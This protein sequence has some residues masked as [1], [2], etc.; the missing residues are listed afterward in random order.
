MIVLVKRLVTF[1][2]GG[3]I[4]V[5]GACAPLPTQIP[6][7]GVTGIPTETPGIP[8]TGTDLDNT[9]WMF[10][11]FSEGGAG[12][13]V[14][15]GTNV[16]LSFQENGQ[17]GGSGGCNAFSTQYQAGNGTIS[18]GPIAST[19]MACTSEGVT[20]QEQK[21]FDALQSADRYELA[22]DTLRILYVNGQNSLAFSRTTTITPVQPT[23]SLTM[24]APTMVHSTAT[25]VEVNDAERI[26]FKPG[27]TS[28]SLTGKLAASASK[29]YVLRALAGQTMS[30]NLT[31]TEG[32]AILLVWGEDGDVLLSDHAEASRL[33]RVLPTTQDYFI[34]VKGGP[35]GNTSYNMT[36]DIP[37]LNTG[38]ERIEFPSGGTSAT[39]AGQLSATDSDQ[40]IFSAQ[41]GQTMNID[42]TFT[43]G[44]A[45]LVVWGADGNVL[46]SDHAEASNF[47]GVVPATQDYYISVK[48]WPDGN[49]SYSMTISIPPR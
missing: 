34:Q 33:E 40:Y 44:R 16:T 24:L 46:L 17:A 31:F 14:I 39:V 10:V 19:K 47:R 13:P 43:I 42:L 6:T 25:S 41:A 21:F 49:N 3:L 32:Q 12:I 22:G 1:F 48:G 8:I 11:S 38:I 4:V 36:I 29:L 45:I 23:P 30:V 9:Q 20:E 28:I 5:L 7:A 35:D 27:T 15:S 18:F 26:T 37:A 2:M